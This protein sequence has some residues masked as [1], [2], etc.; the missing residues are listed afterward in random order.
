MLKEK[1]Y[2]DLT[3]R[4]LI[5]NIADKYG[6]HID[7]KKSPWIRMANQSSNMTTS[8]ISAFATQMI[9]AATKQIDEL[10]DYYVVPQMMEIN[11]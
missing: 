9:Y 6:A 4:T 3:I 5:K 8:A 10:S 1:G 7:D 2:Y 11:D